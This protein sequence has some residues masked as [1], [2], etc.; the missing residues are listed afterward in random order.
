MAKR[1]IAVSGAAV[2]ALGPAVVLAPG[3]DATGAAGAAGETIVRTCKTTVNKQKV[4]LRAELQLR[5]A[6]DNDVNSVSIRATDRDEAGGFKNSKVDLRK[7]I[8][9]V[10]DE[11]NKLVAK[12]ETP[13][14]PYSVDLGNAS[15]EVGRVH[16]EA[17]WRSGNEV[18]VVECNFTFSDSDTSGNG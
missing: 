3:A 16:T 14:S 18:R 15:N 10:K 17:R 1:W 5:S 13:S 4:K 9:R 11:S 12:G 2:L 6:D 7:I 8:L